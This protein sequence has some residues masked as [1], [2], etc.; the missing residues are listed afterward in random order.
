MRLKK[1]LILFYCSLY[2]DLKAALFSKMSLISEE[3]FWMNDYKKL[4]LC[5]RKG[6]FC[7]ADFICKE[8]K[9]LCLKCKARSF[10]LVC[11]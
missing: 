8:D 7:V 6:A 10:I 4:E 1:R 11:V 3:F 2:D 5:V 9:V